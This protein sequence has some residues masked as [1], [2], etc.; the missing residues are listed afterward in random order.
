VRVVDGRVADGAGPPPPPPE[1]ET[2]FRLKARP[3]KGGFAR[4]PV[5]AA[6]EGAIPLGAIAWTRTAHERFHRA[7]RRGFRGLA[8]ALLHLVFAALSPIG[9][10]ILPFVQSRPFRA[11]NEILT[12]NGRPPVRGYAPAA[13]LLPIVWLAMGA[14]VLFRH[15]LSELHFMAA[16]VGG[17]V[18]LGAICGW[19]QALHNRFYERVEAPA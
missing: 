2:K 7:T 8:A 11:A 14:A 16:L 10:F 15:R 13:I 5:L 18:L 3:P 1:E 12:A 19:L 9:L 4:S 6:L 17:H